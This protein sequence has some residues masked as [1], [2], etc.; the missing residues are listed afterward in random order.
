MYTL[1]HFFKLR[2]EPF[3]YLRD[4]SFNILYVQ[5]FDVYGTCRIDT[6]LTDINV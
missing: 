2:N 4:I 3:V 1:F 6:L 5:G